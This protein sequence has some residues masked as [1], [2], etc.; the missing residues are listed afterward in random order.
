M[1]GKVRVLTVATVAS[2]A[3]AGVAFGA[4]K[5]VIVGTSGNDTL[6]G[7]PSADVMYGKAGNDTL[8]GR[9]GNDVIYGNAGDD[10]LKGGDGRDV[11]YGGD[12]NDS[13]WGGLDSDIEYGGA[14]DD[15]LHSLA[16]DNAV[17]I[18]DCGPGNDTA[19]VNSR[20]YA[21][22]LIKLHSCETVVLVSPSSPDV[23]QDT[24]D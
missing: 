15:N 24:G 13:I 19:Y 20:K 23:S 22:H 12:G 14:G 6:W 8:H 3:L 7:T 11:L 16:D 2:L 17:D 21:A 9:A 5:A 10:V 1:Q 18:L 4:T